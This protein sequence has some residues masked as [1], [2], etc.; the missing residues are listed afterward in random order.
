MD[1]GSGSDKPGYVALWP[2]DCAGVLFCR[3]P[4]MAFV[5]RSTRL[6]LAVRGLSA[7]AGRRDAALYRRKSFVYTALTSGDFAFDHGVLTP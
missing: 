4:N 7:R 1:F 5:L 6:R 2:V 3:E